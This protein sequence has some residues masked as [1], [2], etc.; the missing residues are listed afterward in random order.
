MISYDSGSRSWLGPRRSLHVHSFIYVHTIIQET[1]YA[2]NNYI[3]QI[4]YE[5]MQA[6]F[7]DFSAQRNGALLNCHNG[8]IS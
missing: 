4:N 8:S 1:K 6:V 2:Y 5:T 3:K 7:I